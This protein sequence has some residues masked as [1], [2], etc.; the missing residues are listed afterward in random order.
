MNILIRAD[1]NSKIGL[2]HVSRCISLALELETLGA[3]V[4]F[5]A[6]KNEI[7]RNFLDEHNI[8][9]YLFE[10]DSIKKEI[11]FITNFVNKNNIQK[12]IFD[13]Y[14][15]NSN[16]C[17]MYSIHDI[18]NFSVICIEG[19]KKYPIQ[20]D[21]IINPN[22]FAKDRLELYDPSQSKLLFGPEYALLRPIYNKVEEK[23]NQFNNKVLVTFGG[24]DV[25]GL[26]LPVVKSLLEID[27][28][29]IDVV[30]GPYAEKKE[31]IKKISKDNTN[32]NYYYNLTNLL[33]R[34]I[35]ADICVCAAGSTVLELIKFNIPILTYSVA[36]NQKLVA[37]KVEELRLGYNLGQAEE[38]C[39]D[40]LKTKIIEILNNKR[41]YK[42]FLMNCE[43]MI[44]SNTT[45]KVAEE[46]MKK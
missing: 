46:I 2:G 40:R 38:F 6:R 19:Y 39:E 13:S 9:Y 32:L 18:S 20:A 45:R 5:L 12:G 4:Y 10:F 27:N 42:K 3:E 17:Y 11:S 36:D 7:V 15:L 29:K 26:T 37:K 1:G 34:Y 41:Q 21:V 14:E 28:I 30:V 33:D 31:T 16:E 8:N 35:Q 22:L 43:N 23:N 44:N 25:K 24:G